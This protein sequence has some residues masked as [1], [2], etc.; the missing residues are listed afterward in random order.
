VDFLLSSYGYLGNSIAYQLL[1]RRSQLPAGC[2]VETTLE[3]IFITQLRTWQMTPI[4]T[5]EEL[6]HHSQTLLD[7]I[8]IFHT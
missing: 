4:L 5:K 7:F 3:S 1:G 2:F 8:D 6:C